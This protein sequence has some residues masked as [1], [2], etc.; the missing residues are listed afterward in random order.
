M[1]YPDWCLWY[2]MHLRTLTLLHAVT[3]KESSQGAVVGIGEFNTAVYFCIIHVCN[4][5][6]CPCLQCWV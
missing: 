1:V 5:V 4:S 3:D 2:C 6:P